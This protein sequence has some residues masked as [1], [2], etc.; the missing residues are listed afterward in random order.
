[1]SYKTILVNLDIDGP[2]APVVRLAAGLAARFDAK[3]VGFCAAD[4]PLPMASPD[5]AGLAAEVWQQLREDIERRQKELHAEFDRIVA[6]SV[7][8]EWRE[9]LDSPTRALTTASRLAD[10]VI[11]SASRNASTGNAYR[12]ADPGSVVLQAGRPLLVAA[13]NTE[14]VPTKTVVIAWKD[15]REARRAVADAVPLL[16]SAKEVIVVTVDP[17]PDRWIGAGIAD[18]AEFLTRHGIKPR[19]EMVEATN[20]GEKLSEF[21]ASCHADLVVSGAYGHSRLREWVFGG[22][23]RSLL[24]QVGLNRFMSS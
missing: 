21:V 22:V 6:G 14:Q 9:S 7:E 17:A 13:E 11:M 15:T 5:G 2:V 10:L 16:L 20:E 18:V 3:L 8:A 23:T 1:M 24:D 12:V 4:A 19:T